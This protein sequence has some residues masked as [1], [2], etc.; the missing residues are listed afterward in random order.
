MDTLCNIVFIHNSSKGYRQEKKV[1]LF[2]NN[3]EAVFSIPEDNIVVVTENID[4][5]TLL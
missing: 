1:S 3:E 5:S 4:R 2:V